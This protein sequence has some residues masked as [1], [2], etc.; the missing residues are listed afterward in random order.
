MPSTPALDAA[1]RA[2]ARR[3]GRTWV[4][5]VCAVLLLVAQWLL[6]SHAPHDGHGHDG[7]EAPHACVICLFKATGQDTTGPL[8]ALAATSV[9]FLALLGG[10]Q[11]RTDDAPGQAPRSRRLAR[12]PPV[13]AW[14]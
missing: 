7:D 3:A 14:R 11:A 13:A 2:P 5:G 10:V 6:L 9:P 4:L 12:G 8:P 1:P